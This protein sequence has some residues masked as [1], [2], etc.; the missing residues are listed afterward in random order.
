MRVNTK[1]GKQS[2]A[3]FRGIENPP[4]G[5]VSETVKRLQNEYIGGLGGSDTYRSEDLGSLCCKYQP[6]RKMRE[7][8]K[9]HS[10]TLSVTNDIS[11]FPIFRTS[12]TYL[13]SL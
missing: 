2:V 4:W 11:V 5:L 1:E 12:L 8:K 7:K 6:K 9:E 3:C 10:H 13:N